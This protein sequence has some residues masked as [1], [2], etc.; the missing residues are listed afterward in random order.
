MKINFIYSPQYENALNNGGAISWRKAS[1]SKNEMNLIWQKKGKDIEY[2]LYKITNL[3]FTENETTCYLNSVFSISD[4]FSLQILND[5][6]TMTDN[7]IHELIHILLTQ[8]INIIQKKIAVHHKR[9]SKYNFTTRIHILVHAVHLELSKL[10]YPQRIKYI[11]SFS[12]DN[13]YVKSWRIV[14]VIGSKKILDIL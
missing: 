14:D 1:K 6:K 13:S 5:K 11:K 7:L 3:K 12:K 4:P 10:I 2:T 8:N 9:F